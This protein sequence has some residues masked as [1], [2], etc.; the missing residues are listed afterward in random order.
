VLYTPNP[1]QTGVLQDA[2]FQGCLNQVLNNTED[3]DPALVTTLACPEAGISSLIGIDALSN[4]EQLDLGGNAITD[5]SPLSRLR[6][7]RVLNL[8]DNS[9]RSVTALMNL[10]LLR[11]ISLQGNDNI[12][13]RQLDNLQDKVGNTLNRPL[14][15]VG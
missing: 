3:R 6:N 1:Q 11:I 9:V 13:C 12:P 14:S 8:R 7:L 4:L 15:C 5:L 10:P 2:N